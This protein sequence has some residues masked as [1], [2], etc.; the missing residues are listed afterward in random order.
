MN[1]TQITFDLIYPL[2]G[3]SP[4]DNSSKSGLD[5]SRRDTSWL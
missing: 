5:I 3:G 2:N 4:N 1:E